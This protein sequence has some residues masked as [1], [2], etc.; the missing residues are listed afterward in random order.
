[1]RR[2][3]QCSPHRRGIAIYWDPGGV[4][5]GSTGAAG[6]LAPQPEC[7]DE[8]RFLE[9]DAREGR[10]APQLRPA[11][12]APGSA[13]LTKVPKGLPAPCGTLIVMPL[14]CSLTSRT[15]PTRIGCLLNV[16]CSFSHRTDTAQTPTDNPESAWIAGVAPSRPA[17]CRSSSS[18]PTARCRHWPDYRFGRIERSRKPASSCRH[19]PSPPSVQA[20]QYGPS[21]QNGAFP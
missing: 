6:A 10:P 2:W 19:P 21:L 3:S 8:R 17:C 1:M 4:A 16:E 18:S 7:E 15:P 11:R 20:S 13:Q 9:V 12:A 14:Y 5:T